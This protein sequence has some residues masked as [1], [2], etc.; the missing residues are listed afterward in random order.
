MICTIIAGRSGTGGSRG[1]TLTMRSL[2]L[3]VDASR[4]SLE[5]LLPDRWA[6][7]P[8]NGSRGSLS[9]D[10]QDISRR[11][12]LKSIASEPEN[13]RVRAAS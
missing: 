3:S 11:N 6:V 7:A 8:P 10:G 2:Q 12:S 5:G 9:E 1:F 13:E 4:A